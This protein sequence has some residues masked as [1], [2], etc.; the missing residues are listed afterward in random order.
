MDNPACVPVIIVDDDAAVRTSL[1]YVLEGYDFAVEDYGDG[2]SFLAAAD[3]SQPSCVILDYRMPGLNGQEVHAALNHAGSCVQ[4]IF[5][6]SHADIPMTIK[7]FRD[8]ACDFHQKPVMAEALIPSI[9][10]AQRK[11]LECHARQQKAVRF[12]ALTRRERQIFD[13]VVAGRMNKQIAYELSISQR[14][15]EVHR[16]K[17]MERLGVH[18]ITDLMRIAEALQ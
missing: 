18:S 14:T 4:V 11:S 17:M 13:L 8:G 10:R 6:T 1:R 3:L 12:A 9:E 15:V 16:A 2:K 5:L 7:A